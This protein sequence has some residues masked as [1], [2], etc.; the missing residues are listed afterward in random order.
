MRQ[1]AI[2]LMQCELGARIGGSAR[3]IPKTNFAV[4]A[5][6]YEDFAARVKCNRV[7]VVTSPDRSRPRCGQVPDTNPAIERAG[8]DLVA[9]G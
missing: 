3:S 6:G 8:G 7:D 9:R 2:D 4:G 1:Q 5:S